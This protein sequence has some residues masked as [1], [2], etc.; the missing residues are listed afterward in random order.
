MAVGAQMIDV[1]KLIVSHGM[2]VT[3][4]G[5]VVGTIGAFA[6]ARI[7]AGSI[8][9]F[10]FEVS[11]TDLLTFIAAPVLLILVALVACCAAAVP[12]TK[13]DPLVALRYE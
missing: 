13:V 1:L 4:I 7:L 6:A 2:K 3:L 8:S 11:A 5:V 12:A 9:G 10:L